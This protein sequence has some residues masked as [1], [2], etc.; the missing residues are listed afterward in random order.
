MRPDEVLPPGSQGKRHFG[1]VLPW[2][3]WEQ[4]ERALHDADI[5]LLAAPEVTL[6]LPYA[7]DDLS[8]RTIN[9]AG[10]R[11]RRNGYAH[12]RAALLGCTETVMVEDGRLCLGRWQRVL[13]AE[14]D[15][16]QRR[17]LQVW[18]LSS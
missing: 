12:C 10:P 15:G 14:F 16:P 2:R 11:E 18:L 1:V 3:E 6:D 4:L 7:H 8:R 5:R 17:D 13:F 9:V